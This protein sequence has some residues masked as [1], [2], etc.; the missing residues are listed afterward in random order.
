[1]LEALNSE[2]MME[3]EG[4]FIVTGSMVVAGLGCLGVGVA[5]GYAVGKIIKHFN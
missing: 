1:M 5:T 4:G 2:D 3:I